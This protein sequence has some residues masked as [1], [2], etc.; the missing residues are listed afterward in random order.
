[1][2]ETVELRTLPVQRRSSE[3]LTALLD[4]AARLIDEKGLDQVTTTAVAYFSNSSVGVLYRYFP[5]VDSLLRALAWRNLQRY[6]EA[7][8]EA[9]DMSP[10]MPWSSWDYTL[11]AYVN[12]M[13]HEPSFRSLGFGEVVSSKFLD[14]KL[15]INSVI[16]QA[17]AQQVSETHGVPVVPEMLF[18]LEV[19][20]TWGTSMMQLA[21]ADD[22]HGDERYIEHARECIGNYLRTYLPIT[23]S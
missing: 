7:V 2:T 16:T 23:P 12:M 9:S 17:F 22:P 20:V 6:L 3:R 19:A 10:R 4:A 15:S 18:H 5:N 13:R 8:A 14:E 21:F 1:M 11:D